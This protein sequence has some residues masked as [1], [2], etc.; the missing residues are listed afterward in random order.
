MSA[1]T[2][3]YTI[4]IYGIA[5]TVLLNEDDAKRRGLARRRKTVVP[6]NTAAVP[7]NKAA[8]PAAT[9]RSATRKTE[10]ETVPDA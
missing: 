2:D 9:K 1:D 8:A 10:P 7:E 6:E 4:D 3:E 5:H